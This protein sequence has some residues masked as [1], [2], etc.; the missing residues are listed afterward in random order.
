MEPCWGPCRD[1]LPIFVRTTHLLWTP[2]QLDGLEKVAFDAHTT[3]M[4]TQLTSDFLCW[5]AT[6]VMKAACVRLIRGN[7]LCWISAVVVLPASGF[8][9]FFLAWIVHIP[10]SLCQDSPRFA[11]RTFLS[12]YSK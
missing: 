10:F 2:Q 5:S 1:F 9:F 7:A 4:H 12:V 3:L 6:A 11:L 8:V